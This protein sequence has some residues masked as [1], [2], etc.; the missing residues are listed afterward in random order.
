MWGDEDLRAELSRTQERLEREERRREEAE[1]EIKELKK[2]IAEQEV[3][4]ERYLE[5][6]NHLLT[7]IKRLKRETGDP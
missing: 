4:E 5:E 6:Q 1:A 7:T 3:N 2:Q